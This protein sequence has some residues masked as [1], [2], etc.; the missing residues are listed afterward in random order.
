MLLPFTPSP[1]E[2]NVLV[3]LIL[4]EFAEKFVPSGK[5]LY[6]GDTFEK[7][8]YFDDVSLQELGIILEP[9]ENLPDIVLH[10]RARN[11]LVLIDASTHHGPITPARHTELKKLFEQSHIGL[12]F[13]T[14]FLDHK[15]FQEELDNIS[16][17]T[18]VWVAEAPSHLIHFD[19]ERFLGPY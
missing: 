2:Q 8:T 19:G 10:D 4:G 13:V 1:D 18:D 14:A 12:V 6:L 15:D 11:W 17:E 16:W 5:L 9:H 3:K 7:S